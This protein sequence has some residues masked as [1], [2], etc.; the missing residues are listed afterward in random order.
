MADLEILNV[1]FSLDRIFL[2]EKVENEIANVIAGIT[3]RINKIH[4][5]QTY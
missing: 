3:S 2:R 1:Q 5:F 4:K